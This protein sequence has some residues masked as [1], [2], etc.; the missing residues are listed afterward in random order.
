VAVEKSLC[1]KQFDAAAADDDD[2]KLER[3]GKAKRVSEMREEISLR[4][5]LGVS[6][7]KFI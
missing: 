1:T 4:N 6:N 2:E 3:D 7:L 5:E